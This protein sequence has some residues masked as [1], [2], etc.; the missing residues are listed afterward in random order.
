MNTNTL[1]IGPLGEYGGDLTLNER[2]VADWAEDSPQSSPQFPPDSP[3]SDGRSPSRAAWPVWQPMSPPVKERVLEL[4]YPDV[5]NRPDQAYR[6][7]SPGA[8]A[9]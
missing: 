7:V 3:Q 9:T 4:R 5:R 6:S 8:P 1:V 2:L